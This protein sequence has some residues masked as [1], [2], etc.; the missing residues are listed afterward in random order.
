[1]VID[2][3]VI[4]EAMLVAVFLSILAEMPSGPLALV[5]SRDNNRSN[6]VSSLQS[7]CSGHE[8]SESDCTTSF[9]KGGIDRLKHWLKKVLSI[10]AFWMLVEAVS[11]AIFVKVG[12]VDCFFFRYLMALQNSL[13]FLGFNFSKYFL[14]DSL[15]KAVVLFLA[16]LYFEKFPEVLAFLYKLFLF[17]IDCTIF[18]ESQGRFLR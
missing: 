7:R 15:S 16:F 11:P 6:T 4:D 2:F 5:V 14:L 10:L 8:L 13:G 3:F 12:I 18:F 17:L 1:M 9:S